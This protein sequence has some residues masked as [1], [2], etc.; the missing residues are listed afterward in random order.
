MA[1][2]T[3]ILTSTDWEKFFLEELNLSLETAQSYSDEFVSQ[4]ITGRNIVFGLAE[5]GFLNQFNMSVGHQLELKAIFTA[6]PTQTESGPS[7]ARPQN[8]VPMPSV[9]MNITQLDFD[10]FTF[11]WNRY[12]EHYQINQNTATS[13]FFCCNDEVRQQ[14]RL[15]QASQGLSWTEQSLMEAIQQTVLSRVSPIVHVKEFLEIKQET[16]ESVQQFLQ[17]LQAKASCC[18]FYC[19]TC[20]SSNIESRVR[21]KF[22]LG[23]KDTVVQRSALKTASVTPDTSLSKLLTEAITLEQSM[24]DQK[25]ISTTIAEENTIC[26]IDNRNSC[27]CSVNAATLMRNTKPVKCTHCGLTDHSSYERREKCPAWGKRC[28][29]CQILNHFKNMCLKPQLNRGEDTPKSVALAEILFVGEVSSTSQLSV[30]VMPHGSKNYSSIDVVPDTGSNI[31]LMGPLQL[32]QLGIKRSSMHKCQNQIGVAGGTTIVTTGWVKVKLLLQ[33]RYSETTVYFAKRAK[34]FFLS[35]KCCQ[36]LQIIP[37]SFPYPAGNI[38]VIDPDLVT[39]SYH[40]THVSS[41][42]APQKPESIS[43]RPTKGNILSLKKKQLTTATKGSNEELHPTTDIVEGNGIE[44]SNETAQVHTKKPSQHGITGIPVRIAASNI[45]NQPDVQLE[46]NT[47]GCS[48]S[49][50]PSSTDIS[51]PSTTLAANHC[52]STQSPQGIIPTHTML[53]GPNLCAE[54]PAVICTTSSHPGGGYSVSHPLQQG[55]CSFVWP[56]RVISAA[57]L[58]PLIIAYIPQHQLTTSGYIQSSI[59]GKGVT[60]LES[61]GPTYTASAGMATPQH[62]LWPQYL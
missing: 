47:L 11:E 43:V 6:T 28:N 45:S 23:L 8:K 33:E 16:Q 5:P 12:K 22:I 25:S 59:M 26:S 58:E 39:P 29:N 34:H 37:M 7:T 24:R 50:R 40:K 36:D 13:L 18:D 14:I 55:D 48:E 42:V 32:N 17:R 10:Q 1:L 21:E 62:I 60:I 52:F 31:C 44:V 61:Q 2:R 4:N 30:G 27:E 51:F 46:V 53:V 15:L 3:N 9:K 35:R 38:A 49:Q 20:S 41:Q 57:Q 19:H 56:T 54:Q